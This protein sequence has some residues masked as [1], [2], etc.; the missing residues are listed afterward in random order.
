MV[1]TRRSA[2][3][4]ETRSD[5][6]EDEFDLLDDVL[7]GLKSTPV[8]DALAGVDTK[9]LEANLKDYNAGK[10]PELSGT[11]E[12]PVELPGSAKRKRTKL[13]EPVH[14]DDTAQPTD[15]KFAR[16]EHHVEELTE[17]ATNRAT[18]HPSNKA[19][20]DQ[21][22]LRSLMAQ[23][24][25]AVA[26]TAGA[27][28]AGA[29]TPGADGTQTSEPARI[30]F[31]P[32]TLI[33]GVYHHQG[34]IQ[35]EKV[36][37]NRGG[38]AVIGSQ[39]FRGSGT[40]AAVADHL[41]AL[42]LFF[43]LSANGNEAATTALSAL[44]DSRVVIYDCPVQVTAGD[45]Q[46]VPPGIDVANNDFELAD[47][48]CRPGATLYKT[49]MEYP[50]V[51]RE[52]PNRVAAMSLSKNLM[53][54]LAW[55]NDASGKLM[56]S[57]LLNSDT[58]VLTTVEVWD[59]TA[60]ATLRAHTS[61]PEAIAMGAEFTFFFVSNMVGASRLR[62]ISTSKPG[63]NGGSYPTPTVEILSQADGAAL[64]ARLTAP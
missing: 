57:G 27:T 52:V 20:P 31:E 56:L 45:N 51:K 26:T 13:T 10:E 40:D 8:E 39:I 11:A 15:A 16:R 19:E 54:V 53:L 9:I 47:L 43:P 33:P 4:K 7:N 50:F 41:E 49:D 36:F 22:D 62:K 23:A 6:L 44:A 34:Q 2:T 29:T 55:N 24:Q 25:Q 42:K 64:L 58:Q 14:E 1:G 61:S 17:V 35:V 18:V 60:S 46:Y 21:V 59:P 48:Y 30:F 38:A 28:T 12:Q 37:R 63:A 5:P 32:G 3:N